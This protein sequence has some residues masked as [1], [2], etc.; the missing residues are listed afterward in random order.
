MKRLEVRMARALN[1]VMDR[2][3][4]VFSDRLRPLPRAPPDGAARGTVRMGVRAL[5]LAHPRGARGAGRPPRRR[6]VQLRRRLCRHAA[7]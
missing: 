2:K 4:P 3:G 5:Q 1:K 6:P 7:R